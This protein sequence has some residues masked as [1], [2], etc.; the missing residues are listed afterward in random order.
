MSAAI[1]WPDLDIEEV[2]IVYF[3]FGDSL[4]PGDTIL[5]A[6]V[7]CV[8][9]RGIDAAPDLVKVG[10]AVIDGLDVWQKVRGRTAGVIY[11][12]R[13]TAAAQSGRVKVVAANLP[14]KRF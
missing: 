3:R 5:T 4:P 12:L 13:C 6:D 10:L 1:T 7:Q 14:V 11:H 9:E 2:D 8:V